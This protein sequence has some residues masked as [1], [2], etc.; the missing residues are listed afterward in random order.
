L[1]RCLLVNA[2]FY[3]CKRLLHRR[4]CLLFL[5][6][7]TLFW[8]L[9]SLILPRD[10][11]GEGQPKKHLLLARRRHLLQSFLLYSIAIYM[12]IE[13]R[14]FSAYKIWLLLLMLVICML[15]KNFLRID[16]L[17]CPNFW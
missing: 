13:T 8:A 1:I 17:V 9:F 10:L 2:P 3:C 16:F 15:S 14:P 4:I 5:L 11:N 7:L 6:I 12:N